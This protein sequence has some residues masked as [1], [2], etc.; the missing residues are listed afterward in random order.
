MFRVRCSPNI[1]LQSSASCSFLLLWLKTFVLFFLSLPHQRC[2][3][4]AQWTR[5]SEPNPRVDHGT[6][7]SRPPVEE[8]SRPVASAQ[9]NSSRFYSVAVITPDSDSSEHSGNPGSIPGRTFA[10]GGRPPPPPFHC[11]GS[12]SLL[13]LLPGN[14]HMGP[15]P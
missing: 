4:S 8:I 3:S 15:G 1:S 14:A 9:R 7:T 5:S 11:L 13:F 12:R 6:C 2:S 10:F